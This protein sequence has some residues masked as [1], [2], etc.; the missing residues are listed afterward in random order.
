MLVPDVHV[1]LLHRSVALD[2]V[3]PRIRRAGQIVLVVGVDLQVLLQHRDLVLQEDTE[4]N[5]LE[6][7]AETLEG[8]VGE[9]F[10][11]VGDL[12]AQA[13]QLRAQVVRG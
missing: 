6:G 7:L 8:V 11:R 5:V 2:V 4:L 1:Q 12:V 10:H 9:G 13:V 3:R